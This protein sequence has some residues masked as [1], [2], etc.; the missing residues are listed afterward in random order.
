MRQGHKHQINET[1]DKH[2]EVSHPYQEHKAMK[3]SRV[4]RW[5][6]ARKCTCLSDAGVQGLRSGHC[7][8]RESHL[9]E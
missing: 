6:Q 4:R 7:F 2:G 1:S 8:E 3:S 5:R 9:S